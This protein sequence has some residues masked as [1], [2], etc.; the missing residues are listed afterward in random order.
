MRDVVAG[1]MLSDFFILSTSQ[2]IITLIIIIIISSSSSSGPSRKNLV[3][4]WR[5]GFCDEEIISAIASGSTMRSN[6]VKYRSFSRDTRHTSTQQQSQ[7][8]SCHSVE[9]DIPLNTHYP[10]RDGQDELM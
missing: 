1:D 5:D 7:W 8:Q 2:T 3:F 9:Q 6:A 4:P 10:R